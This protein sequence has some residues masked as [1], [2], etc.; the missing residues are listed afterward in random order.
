MDHLPTAVK[1]DTV[2]LERRLRGGGSIS[3]EERHYLAL[4]ISVLKAAFYDRCNFP[5]IC[6]EAGEKDESGMP[7]FYDICPM[8]G[9]GGSAQY[10]RSRAYSEPEW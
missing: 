1:M 9:V 3:E 5:F 10:R 6:G 8:Y 4:A 7:E 2:D